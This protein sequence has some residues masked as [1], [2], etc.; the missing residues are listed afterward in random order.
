VQE[1]LSPCADFGKVN[2]MGRGAAADPDA[3]RSVLEKNIRFINFAI[4]IPFVTR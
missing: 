2:P 1:I 4:A 3:A